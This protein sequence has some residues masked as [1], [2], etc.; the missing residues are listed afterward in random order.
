ML[1]S[2]LIICKNKVRVDILIVLLDKEAAPTW[3]KLDEREY[4][5]KSY[6]LLLSK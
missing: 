4:L 6:L 1:S 3:N 5:L 2:Y